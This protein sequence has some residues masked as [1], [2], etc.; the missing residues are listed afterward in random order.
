MAPHFGGVHESMI[1]SAKTAIKAILG[2]ADIN[3]KELNSAFVGAE[4][5]INS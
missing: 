3:D 1:K 2:S 5:L 4:A